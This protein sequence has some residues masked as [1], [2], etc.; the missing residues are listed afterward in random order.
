MAKNKLSKS[1]M[2]S[3]SKGI[4]K[5]AKDISNTSNKLIKII[6]EMNGSVYY[7]GDAANKWYKKADDSV[8][9]NV[10]FLKRLEQTLAKIN[11]LI[12]K[13]DNVTPPSPTAG[14]TAVAG[15]GAAAGIGAGAGSS[16]GNNGAEL[17]GGTIPTGTGNNNNSNNNNN[18][19]SS[20]TYGHNDYT[21]GSNSNQSNKSVAPASRVTQSSSA[22]ISAKT[23]AEKA[24]AEQKK[25]VESNAV[26]AA[27]IGTK[28]SVTAARDAARKAEAA[29]QTQTMLANSQRKRIF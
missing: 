24:A 13:M 4:S 6:E 25:S 15:A 1:K 3:L 18:S 11:E 17:G 27:S 12:K 9:S 16:F 21:P 26:R 8:T 5:Y 23:L 14:S 20:K 29:K 28:E 19:A 7:G 22:Q 10:N 2:K